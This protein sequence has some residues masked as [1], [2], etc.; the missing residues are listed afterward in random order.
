[1]NHDFSLNDMNTH[2]PAPRKIPGNTPMMD[3]EMQELMPGRIFGGKYRLEK[4]AGAGGMGIVWKAWDTVGERMVALKFVPAEIRH[5]DDAMTRVKRTFKRI[6][7]L[8]H[9]HICPVY[10]LEKDTEVGFYVVMKWL[11]GKSLATFIEEEKEEGKS[12]LENGQRIS[13]L[14]DVAEA[15][16]YAHARGVIHRDVKP[17]NIFL[18][19]KTENKTENARENETKIRTG[20]ETGAGIRTESETEIKSEIEDIYLIDFGLASEILETMNQYSNREIN[21]SGTR[22][23]MPPEQWQGKSQTAQTDQYALGVVAYELFSGKRPFQISDVEMLRLAIL[24]DVPD[25][26]PEVSQ[27]VNLTILRAL[28]KNPAERFPSCTDF[29][30]ALTQMVSASATASYSYTDTYPQGYYYPGYGTPGY[31]TQGYT[32]S[33]HTPQVGYT[34]SG[35]T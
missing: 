13:I 21:T 4:L 32:Q 26:I 31:G 23:Y 2:V 19:F 3:A 9:T 16:D 18:T 11:E 14:R 20:T 12:K 25:S 30:N 27:S 35:Y 24:Q 8:N 6:Q 34:Q 22:P 15:L 5:L 17:S 33:G 7:V 28:A 29:V 1:M 10:G